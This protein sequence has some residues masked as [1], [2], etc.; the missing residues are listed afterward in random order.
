MKTREIHGLLEA[1][2][3]YF[4]SG[5]TLPVDFR[6]SQLRKLYAAVKQHEKEILKRST[7]TLAKARSK[8]S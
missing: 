5:A 2:S 3:R 4:K 6:L 1:Q 7:R 8:A